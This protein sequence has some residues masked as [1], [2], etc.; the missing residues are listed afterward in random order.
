MGRFSLEKAGDKTRRFWG[1]FLFLGDWGSESLF[2]FLGGERVPRCR[3]RKKTKKKRKQTKKNNILP[4]LM[5]T[6]TSLPSQAHME[7]NENRHM[8][9]GLFAC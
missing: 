1:G 3:P 7:A 9:H 8:S 4:H 2:F 5:S 6:W